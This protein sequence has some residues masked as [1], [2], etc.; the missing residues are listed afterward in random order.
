MFEIEDRSWISRSVIAAQAEAEIRFCLAP[1]FHPDPYDIGEDAHEIDLP[2][3][4]KHT[5][6]A[7]DVPSKTV[8]GQKEALLAHYR[9]VLN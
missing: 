1:T 9:A 2:P 3:A 6:H 7:Y 8:F 4:A 5:Q